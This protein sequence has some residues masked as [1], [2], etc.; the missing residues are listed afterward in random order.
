M[1]GGSLLD[2]VSAPGRWIVG[3]GVGTL[4]AAGPFLL[5]WPVPFL[6]HDRPHLTGFRPIAAAWRLARARGGGFW[7]AGL[8]AY[9]CLAATVWFTVGGPIAT[10]RPDALF[11]ALFGAAICTGIGLPLTAP[12]TVLL[13]A[14]AY[15]RAERGRADSEGGPPLDAGGS[16]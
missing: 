5:L 14:H 13:L 11:P 8:A 1:I 7:S 15:D 9:A 4:L 2:S 10:A 6:I 16:F 12:P 3:L